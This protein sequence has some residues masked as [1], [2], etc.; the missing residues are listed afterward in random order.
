ME[1][2]RG[3]IN[4]MRAVRLKSD[5]ATMVEKVPES[6]CAACDSDEHSSCGDK[7]NVVAQLDAPC[8][9]IHAGRA[10]FKTLTEVLLK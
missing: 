2:R 7:K 8:S 9:G 10:D 1:R 4:T 3:A 6:S 5:G